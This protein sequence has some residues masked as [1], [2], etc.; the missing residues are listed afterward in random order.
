VLKD[1]PREAYDN[2]KGIEEEAYFLNT[3]GLMGQ[4]VGESVGV[5]ESVLCGAYTTPGIVK[6]DP[7]LPTLLET[8]DLTLWQHVSSAHAND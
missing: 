4:R 8:S 2:R 6:A 3:L 1:H 7:S 5:M